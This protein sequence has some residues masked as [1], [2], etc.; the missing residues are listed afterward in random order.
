MYVLTNCITICF[1]ITIKPLFRYRMMISLGGNYVKF[2]LYYR[3]IHHSPYIEPTHTVHWF[4]L[5]V[6]VERHAHMLFCSNFW[7]YQRWC[8]Y[9][10]S[11]QTNVFSSMLSTYCY[12][13]MSNVILYNELY[14]LVANFNWYVLF[15]NS[16]RLSSIS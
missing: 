7:F 4:S 3:V 13:Q 2:Y 15:Q 5:S 9:S 6:L 11:E 1:S 14:P 10:Q 8:K 12:C 16:I